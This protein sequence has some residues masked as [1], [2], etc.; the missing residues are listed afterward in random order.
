MITPKLIN[1]IHDIVLSDQRIK[2]GEIAKAT[3][4]S[5]GTTK[6]ILNDQLVMK[7]IMARWVPCLL[8]AEDKRNHV[9][10]LFSFNVQAP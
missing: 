4:V 2:L 1:K 7:K 8:S 3:E 9:D 5:K 10:A 6:S